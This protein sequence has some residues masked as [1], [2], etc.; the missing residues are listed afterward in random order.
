MKSLSEQLR[1]ITLKH[2]PRAVSPDLDALRTQTFDFYDMVVTPAFATLHREFGGVNDS[3][4]ITLVQGWLAVRV[5]HEARRHNIRYAVQTGRH[6]MQ[7]RVRSQMIIT[8]HQGTHSTKA[9]VL[10]GCKNK[11]LADISKNDI[12]QGFLNLYARILPSQE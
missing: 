5:Y 3:A 2:D 12:V 8:D 1:D 9:Q 11:A 6:G 7:I 4:V 10:F